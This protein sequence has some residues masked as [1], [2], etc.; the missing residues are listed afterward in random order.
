MLITPKIVALIYVCL[1]TGPD[2]SAD[3]ATKRVVMQR[4]SMFACMMTQ[5]MI[6][7]APHPDDPPLIG[8]N[9]KFKIICA[10]EEKAAAIVGNE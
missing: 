5:S 1:A 6:A 8:K 3:N 7:H 4:E 2:C 10:T 9:E